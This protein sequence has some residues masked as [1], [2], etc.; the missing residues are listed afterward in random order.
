MTSSCLVLF[1]FLEVLP[2]KPETRDLEEEHIARAR[3]IF[4]SQ[5][6]FF[7]TRKFAAITPKVPSK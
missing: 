1:F 3:S 7:F 2:A 6:I 4:L 5:F